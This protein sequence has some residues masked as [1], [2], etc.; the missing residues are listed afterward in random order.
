[1]PET[2]GSIAVRREG[3]LVVAL[4]TGI[5]LFDPKTAF[6]ERHADT[7]GNAAWLTLADGRCDALGRFW[8]GSQVVE[9]GPTGTV[10]RFDPDYSCHPFWSDM[11]WYNGTAWSSDN[12]T[13]FFADSR[14]G[15]I[16]MADYDLETGIAAN[17]RVFATV[18]DS[19]GM[20]DGSTMDAQGYLWNVVWGGGCIIR[21]APTGKIDRIIDLPIKNPTSCAFGGPELTT[22]YITTQRKRMTAEDLLRWPDAGGI[23]S[24]E[25]EVRGLP[26]HRFGG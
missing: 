23:F 12:S 22:L 20:P 24:V 18:P 9:P 4:K 10:Y 1:M 26:E 17:R 11:Y 14:S 19:L 2:V 3:G 25:I 21:Y 7:N 8:V 6:L 16:F 15:T 5:Y 13:M